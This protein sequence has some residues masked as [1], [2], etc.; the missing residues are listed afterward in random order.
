MNDAVVECHGVTRVYQDE[1]V[2]VHALRGVDLQVQRG[3]FVGFSGPSGSGKSTLLNVIGGLD[4]P[5]RGE[6]WVDGLGLNE[7]SESAL[8][9]LRLHKLGFVFQAY[10]LIPVLSA[11]ENVEFIMQ[12]QGVRAGE[13][14]RRATHMLEALG[15]AELEHRRPG[16]LS[17]GQQQRV[18]IARAIVTDPKIIVAD[19][20]TGDLDAISAKAIMQMLQRLN[21]ELGKTLIMVT[22]DPKCAS[23]AQRSL[24][25][26]KGQVVD[27][28]LALAI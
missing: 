28:P 21:Q 3:E 7:L 10:N 26:D 27:A 9:D 17:G 2:P 6:V 13:R 22:H 5:T 24:H 11:R 15:I 1:S 19:E 25:L 23:Y 20:P 8:A 18:A 12:L 16:E 14:R 4:R